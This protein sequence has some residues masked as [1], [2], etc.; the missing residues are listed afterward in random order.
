MNKVCIGCGS[1]FQTLDKNKEG[2]IN[3]KV[4]EK[5]TLC[6]RCFKI[7]Y[8]G[9]AYVTDNPKDKT[10]L[11]KMINDSKKSVVYL[12]DT[13][14]ISKETL[15]VI[16]SLS[17]KVYLVLTKRDLLPKSVKNSKLK[18]YISNL[19]LIKDV[20][21]ISALKNNGV[22]ELYNELIKNNEK[23]VY[24]IGYTSSGKSTF[25]NKL[26]MLNGKS[27]NITTSSLPNTTLECINIKLNDKLTLIDTPGFVSENSS[28]NFI[29]VDIYKKLLP[30]SVIKP[31]VYTIKKDF[32]IILEDILRIENNSN[33]DVNLVFYF[34]NEIK[35][36]KM[37]SIRNKLLKDKDK[38]DV[39]VS[40]KDIILEGLGYIKVVGYANLTMYTLNKK[41]ISVRNKMI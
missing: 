13:L 9:E 10:S 7:K 25:I 23:S 17:N 8:Y 16:D 38:L 27:G 39:K 3:P 18:E 32:M 1:K 34:K 19:T 12:V 36:N 31:K 2:Y 14:T 21:V 30:K 35:L 33:E 6:E 15:S 26:L 22:N 24:V 41:M 5:A 11:I 29:D 20:F 40:D 4:Y 28:Y 37:R